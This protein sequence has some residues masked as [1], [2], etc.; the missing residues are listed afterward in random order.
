MPKKIGIICTSACTMGDHET[1]AWFEEIATP[2][3]ALKEAGMEIVLVSPK[4]G[5]IPLDKGSMQ[6]DFFTADCKKFSDDAEAMAALKS[7]VK[8]EES[9]ADSLDGI[10]LAGGHG[11]MDDFYTNALL[12]AVVEKMYAAN[13]PIA[14]DCH[15]PAA[16]VKCKKPDG[17]PL[18]AGKKMTCFADTE[19]TAVGL[20][21]KVPEMIESA[22]K[23]QGAEFSKADDWHPHAVT[24]GNII[25]GQN[26][27][28][29][30]PCVKQFI[31]YILIKEGE[32]R[33]KAEAEA[34]LAALEGI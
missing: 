21:E 8:L 18:M 9:H 1:G 14:A 29:S 3:Y 11:T 12:H 25:T 32:E 4:G 24:D 15:G 17:T 20:H 19:E 27:A 16:L 6:G 2:Y 28:S 34:K 30:A 31:R 23:A 10:Y 5:E 22:F 33:A 26:P 13:K 7:S